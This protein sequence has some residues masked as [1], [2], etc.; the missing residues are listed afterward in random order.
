MIKLKIKIES[1]GD[2]Y[3][4]KKELPDDFAITMINPDLQKIVLDAQTESHYEQIQDTTLT[5]T[6]YV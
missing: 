4:C 3:V 6:M 1:N 2:Y 5:A